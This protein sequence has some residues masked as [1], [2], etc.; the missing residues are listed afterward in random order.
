[1]KLAFELTM[2]PICGRHGYPILSL[3]LQTLLQVL[4]DNI[5]DTR[6]VLTKKDVQKV[7]L[8]LDGIV[9]KTSD[10]SSYEGDIL[11]GADGNHSTVR[12]E[13]WKIADK[14]APGWFAP[15]EHNRKPPN[16]PSSFHPGLQSHIPSRP[17]L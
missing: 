14:L 3:D 7:D 2:V 11:V 15:D 9:A 8:V 10:G 4:Y 13:M 17:S 6:K 16:P 12:D 5:H 1:M